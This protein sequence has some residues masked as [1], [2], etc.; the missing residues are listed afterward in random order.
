MDRW[1]QKALLVGVSLAEVME[2]HPQLSD[3]GMG[4]VPLPGE[5]SH[6][7]ALRLAAA[8]ADLA[9]RAAKIAKI[10]A[11]LC[12]NFTPNETSSQ[13]SH[14]LQHLVEQTPLG[15]YVSNGQLIAAA[16]IVGYPYRQG[17]DVNVTFGV[18]ARDDR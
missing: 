3:D 15:P 18:R 17:N 10:A 8:R 16:F 6:M 7:H 5:R 13:D 9:L 4:F 12:E 1:L 2:Q 14:Q 11:W